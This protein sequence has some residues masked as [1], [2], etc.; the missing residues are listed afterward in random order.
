VVVPAVSVTAIPGTGPENPSPKIVTWIV[1]ADV[2]PTSPLSAGG[3]PLAV[4]RVAMAAGDPPTPGA[5][6]VSTNVTLVFRADATTVPARKLEPKK[7]EI[8]LGV[9]LA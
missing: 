6:V 7:G 8:N 4:T 3:D 5:A 1:V 2:W 9:K